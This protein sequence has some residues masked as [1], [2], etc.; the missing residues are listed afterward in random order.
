MESLLKKKAAPRAARLLGGLV[1]ALLVGAILPL[2]MA[3]QS[4]H[5]ATAGA[6]GAPTPLPCDA[7]AGAGTQCSA[8]HSV[9]RLLTG[10]YTGPLFQVQRKSDGKTQD[11]YPYTAATLPAGADAKLIG[12]T[13]VGS[14]DRF[15]AS[16]SCV[17]TY[18][19]DQIDLIAALKGSFGNVPG[20]LKLDTKTSGSLTLL[21][22]GKP[23][24]TVPV[25][26]GFATLR[27]PSGPTLT[28]QFIRPFEDG[29]TFPATQNVT[30][31]NDLPGLS[32]HYDA[33]NT[34]DFSYTPL[35]YESLGNGTRIPTLKMIGGN[36]YRNRVGTVNQSIGDSEIAAY[37]VVNPQYSQPSTCCGT[38]G[39]MEGNY[40]PNKQNQ[41]EGLMFGLAFSSGAWAT[42]GYGKGYVPGTN[43]KDF[44]G[45]SDA[46]NN[47]NVNWAGV[48][49]EAG[50]WLYGP[51]RP[52]T[53]SFFT[54]LAKYS[55]AN[56]ANYFA[57]KGGDATQPTL[58][59][60]FNQAPPR[61]RNFGNDAGYNFKG[62][63]EGGLS[64]GE[65]GDA[66]I[67]PVQFFEGALLA[68]ATSAATDNAIQSSIQ[69]F[70]GP[71]RDGT[72]AACYANNLVNLPLSL[73]DT[74]VWSG[75]VDGRALSSA[76]DISGVTSNAAVVSNASGSPFSAIKQWV[77]VQGG[78]T[79]TF[80]DYVLGT[81]DP[82]VKV[83]PGGSVQTDDAG[84]TEFAWVVNTAT[85]KVTR[86]TWG[87]GA[88]TSATSVRTGNWWKISITFTAPAG[89]G[90]ARIF[91]DPPTSDA[92][93]NRSTQNAGLAAT[94]FCPSL[95]IDAS[96]IH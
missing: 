73:T 66:S 62:K 67:A 54:V 69:S 40:D 49:A 55:P 2:G 64:L 47:A 39:N 95:G 75:N 76:V 59:S 80:T 82:S 16:T 84:N 92:S 41:V 10:S 32:G 52:S 79:Y 58:T 61:A 45:K 46:A 35:N 90:N 68:K 21:P 25:T 56:A 30:V 57:V 12:S 87:N 26:N 34:K 65:G 44:V 74:S 20:T 88:I 18:L 85:G 15:C 42:D 70:Y 50:V 89:A 13:N 37:M 27:L 81:S 48:D 38:Y 93:G 9:V 36:A 94:H 51:Q 4:A 63:W 6:A 33:G 14:L 96:V 19:Y 53:E 23:S 1:P 28:I 77:K 86:G 31:G 5:A 29:N 78:Q 24:T 11:V 17:V 91:I 43:Y 3:G 83:F 60:L 22:P 71:P 72:A 8:A 7:A